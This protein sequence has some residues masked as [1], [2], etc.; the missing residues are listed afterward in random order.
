MQGRG[1]QHKVGTRAA[2]SKIIEKGGS[3]GNGVSVQ[4]ALNSK[5][6]HGGSRFWRTVRWA[7]CLASVCELGG[8]AVLG[9]KGETVGAISSIP[10]S[11]GLSVNP[12]SALRGGGG[13]AESGVGTSAHGAPGLTPIYV[14]RPL[15]DGIR[16]W[17]R[18][19]ARQ[20][21]QAMLRLVLLVLVACK[22]GGADLMGG[23]TSHAAD[24]KFSG[25]VAELDGLWMI[26]NQK[27]LK[28]NRTR[29]EDSEKIENIEK[30]KN[31][32]N[33][34]K[35]GPSLFSFPHTLMPAW[36]TM[37]SPRRC[38]FSWSSHSQP[39]KGLAPQRCSPHA[40]LTTPAAAVGL[41]AMRST[42]SRYGVPL[43]GG[44]GLTSQLQPMAL[45]WSCAAK[46]LVHLCVG[47][48]YII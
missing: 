24:G 11:S 35:P 38:N 27:N 5:V 8:A 29:R 20:P 39:E 30:S 33:M 32:E 9:E 25:G 12:L 45:A 2:L 6:K 48:I 43:L 15:D 18:G 47:K 19:E 22:F 42:G 3:A 14:G 16:D 36:V 23:L 17:Q 31:R 10:A 44:I 34:W 1:N 13:C 46:K 37:A 28:K 26:S 4:V 41:G 7:L 21:G 40:C